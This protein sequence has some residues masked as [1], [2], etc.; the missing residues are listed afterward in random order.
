MQI[1][2][3]SLHFR[4]LEALDAMPQAMPGITAVMLNRKFNAPQVLV[5]LE[6]EGLIAEKGWDTGPGA[7]V[8]ATEAGARL[9]RALA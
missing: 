2:R 4:V 9:Y 7:V 6:A 5:E 1:Q 8:V 3:D